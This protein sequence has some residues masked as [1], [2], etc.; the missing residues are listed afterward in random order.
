M[1]KVLCPVLFAALAAALLAASCAPAPQT[2]YNNGVPD[3]R[4][5]SVAGNT[6]EGAEFLAAFPQARAVVDRSGRLAMDLI[7]TKHPVTSTTQS[8][9]GIR[10]RVFIDPMTQLP[11]ET[12]IQCDNTFVRRNLVRYLQQYVET[13]ICP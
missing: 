4:Y 10:L 9:E 5:V 13:Q 3:E 11:T 8:W 2:L 7:V 1:G 6:R 12:F